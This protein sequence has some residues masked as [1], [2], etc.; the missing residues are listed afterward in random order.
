MGTRVRV[1]EGGGGGDIRGTNQTQLQAAKRCTLQDNKNK[2]LHKK[3]VQA[4]P[5]T[6]PAIAPCCTHTD[7]RHNYAPYTHPS[8]HTYLPVWYEHYFR[9][10]VGVLEGEGWVGHQPPTALINCMCLCLRG[11]KQV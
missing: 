11:A 3:Q 6:V 10:W 5:A 2:F 7:T 4:I 8:T 1:S 9:W